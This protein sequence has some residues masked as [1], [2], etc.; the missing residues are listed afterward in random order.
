[1]KPRAKKHNELDAAPLNPSE[2]S[3]RD[4]SRDGCHDTKTVKTIVSLSSSMSTPAPSTL[5]TP[6]GRDA[7]PSPY[8]FDTARKAADTA[9]GDM[10]EVADTSRSHHNGKPHS[11]Q[12]PRSPR[13]RN[14]VKTNVWK[15]NSI[16]GQANRSRSSS[17][18]GHSRTS[19]Q[20]YD[21]E[22]AVSDGVGP[23]PGNADQNI[24]VNEEKEQA[25]SK[26][27]SLNSK[28][29]SGKNVTVETQ[30][31]KF[32]RR[33][34]PK[35]LDQTETKDNEN[36]IHA[37]RKLVA[38][39]ERKAS[40][41]S[42]GTPSKGHKRCISNISEDSSLAFTQGSLAGKL[43]ILE[44]SDGKRNSSHRRPDDQGP[45]LGD[46]KNEDIQPLGI[47]ENTPGKILIGAVPNPLQ[48]SSM[49]HREQAA[50][51]VRDIRAEIATLQARLKRL[52]DAEK[53][54]LSSGTGS[55]YNSRFN[56]RSSSRR[57][58]AGE[59]LAHSL[60]EA[61]SEENLIDDIFTTRRDSLL[62]SDSILRNGERNSSVTATSGQALEISTDSILIDNQ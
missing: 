18:V 10:N 50:A 14:R 22:N 56:S 55:R 31:R 46:G 34:K 41:V 11:T 23:N 17:P 8:N 61:L 6:I 42:L 35:K 40:A 13:A 29:T 12:P 47:E 44:V 37:G 52:E 15:G 7:P 9:K 19:R 25:A 58:S 28:I 30:R 4:A 51:Q 32:E 43:G 27:N 20:Q 24:R 21:Y 26:A 38:R 62:Q 2:S 3:S 45:A 36:Q 39:H 48:I 1:M 5:V 49:N 60:A 54:I 53:R 59:L 16:G 57:N 33:R